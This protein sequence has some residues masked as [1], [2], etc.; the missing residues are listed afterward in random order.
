M[1]SGA[2]VRAGGDPAI[3]LCDV[4]SHPEKY[5]DQ[6]IRMRTLGSKDIVVG[7]PT[8]MDPKVT[9]FAACCDTGEWPSAKLDL[10]TRSAMIRPNVR[11]WV[12]RRSKELIT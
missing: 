11:N 5:Q 4:A 2:D 7:A 1:I 10:G 3:S 6:V 8:R 12:R 9:A